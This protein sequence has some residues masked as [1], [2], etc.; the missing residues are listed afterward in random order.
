VFHNIRPTR[1]RPRPTF[2]VSH[3]SCPKTDGLRPRHCYTVLCFCVDAG[4]KWKNRPGRRCS[5]TR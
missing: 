3:R 1:P 2:L 4:S 5:W